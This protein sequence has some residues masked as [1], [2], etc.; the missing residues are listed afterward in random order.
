M[1]MLHAECRP[2][3]G[4]LLRGMVCIGGLFDL[5]YARFF[6]TFEFGLFDTDS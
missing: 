4:R 1:G 3:A 6:C 2:Q 5:I